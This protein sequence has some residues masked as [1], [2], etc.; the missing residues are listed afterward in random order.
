MV[1]VYIKDFDPE[2][3]RISLGYKKNSENPWV[4]FQNDYH[5]DDVVKVKIVSFTAY[6]AFA[7]IM[8]IITKPPPNVKALR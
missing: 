8:G 4:I 2:K 3:K 1:E 6:G 7:E 5:V